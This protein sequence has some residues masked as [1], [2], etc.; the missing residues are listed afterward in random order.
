M[1]KEQL[2]RKSSWIEWRRTWYEVEMQKVWDEGGASFIGQ[3]VPLTRLGNQSRIYE[4]RY[5]ELTEDSQN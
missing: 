4:F 1:R 5:D 3:T 2:S